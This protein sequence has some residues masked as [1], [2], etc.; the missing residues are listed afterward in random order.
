[1]LGER[2]RRQRPFGRDA[3]QDVV[4]H[5]GV[6]AQDAVLVRLDVAVPRDAVMR[7]LPDRDDVEALVVDL[8]EA[9]V[10]AVQPLLAPFAP[11]A[12]DARV[13]DEVV[14]ARAGHLERVELEQAEPIDDAQDALRLGRQAARRVRGRGADEEAARLFLRCVDQVQLLP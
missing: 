13:Q 7:Q 4:R 1:M 5:V 10:V 6:L 2:G 9:A 11:V 3:L 8:E 12:V 14:V